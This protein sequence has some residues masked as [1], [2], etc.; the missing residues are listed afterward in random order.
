MKILNLTKVELDII[1]ELVEKRVEDA[2]SVVELHANLKKNNLDNVWK[3]AVE[4]DKIVNELLEKINQQ[5]VDY[6]ND[7]D[8][9]LR[10]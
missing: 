4:Y 10:F 2:K 1:R 8:R 9:F 6:G 5:S 7:T 3:L